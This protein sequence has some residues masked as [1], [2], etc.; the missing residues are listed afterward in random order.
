MENNASLVPV[1]PSVV[2]PVAPVPASNGSQG[3]QGK[4]DSGGPEAGRYRLVTEE[5]PSA[6]SFV[7]KTM[8]RLTGEVVKQY[9][10]EK[11]V[12]MQTSP[13]YDAGTV[14]DTAI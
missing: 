9:P 8:D 10:R 6:G 11:L 13:A 14:I 5:G 3:Y 12:E 7:Y 4:K 2:T 1:S